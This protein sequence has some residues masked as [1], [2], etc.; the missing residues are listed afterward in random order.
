MT[1]K[2]AMNFIKYKSPEKDEIL[3]MIF[4]EER[5]E[6]FNF[7]PVSKFI[8][9]VNKQNAINA[10][11][12]KASDASAAANQIMIDYR[13]STMYKNNLMMLDMLANFD[14]KRPINFSSGGIYDSENIFYLDNYLQFD[15]FT[16]RLVPMSTPM[17]SDGDMGR[18]DG[19][20]LY[21]IVKNYKWGNFKNV[22]IH[23]DETATS[24]IIAYR[25]SAGRAAEA[26]AMTGQKA[27]ATELLDLAVKEIPIEK[28]NDPRSL[29]SI[30][31]GYILAGQEA[32]GLKIAEELKK[33][34][35]EEYDYYLSLDPSEQK[36]LRKQMRAKPM[37]YSM[38]VAA[39]TNA[40][41][42]LGQ[43][44]KGYAYLVR[45]VEPIDK[46]FNVFVKTLQ[47]M[48]REKAM[49]KSE[50]VQRITP[51]YQYLFDIMNDYDATYAKE[52]EDQITKAIIKA[53]E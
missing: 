48:G 1:M 41:D 22:N 33:N 15:G 8:L 19:N 47:M 37:E 16:Y 38:V 45:S 17:R 18:V 11:I 35:F 27:K 3:K 43:K 46:K 12:I 14:W 49:K 21:D 25:S 5:Y 30:I 42:K 32:K 26:L 31:Y 39:V 36:Y 6:K 23:Y 7:L 44:N 52:K 9:P 50:D 29:S 13:G 40:F 10:G 4:G 28:Y 20:S 34:I 51:F 53:T 2:E 24:N